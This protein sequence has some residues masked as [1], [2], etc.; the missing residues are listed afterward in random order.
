[1]LRA[2]NGLFIS[3]FVWCMLPLIWSFYILFSTIF[4]LLPITIDGRV[5]ALPKVSNFAICKALHTKGLLT[6]GQYATEVK[7]FNASEKETITGYTYLILPITLFLQ[8]Y[9]T[10]DWLLKLIVLK[11]FQPAHSKQSKKLAIFTYFSYSLGVS[12]NKAKTL[13]VRAGDIGLIQAISVSSPVFAV[14][15]FLNVEPTLLQCIIASIAVIG[16]ILFIESLGNGLHITYEASDTLVYTGVASLIGAYILLMFYL[17]ITP[18]SHEILFLISI[19]AILIGSLGYPIVHELAHRKGKRAKLLYNILSYILLMPTFKIFHNKGHH[20]DLIGT[21]SD[22]VVADYNES[23]IK[24]LLRQVLH[25]SKKGYQ[26]AKF[27]YI[28]LRAIEFLILGALYYIDPLMALAAVTIQIYAFIILETINYVEHYSLAAEPDSKNRSVDSINLLLNHSFFNVGY[29]SH[30]HT[31]PSVHHYDLEPKSK[32][33]TNY[34]YI[35]Q[36]Y[37]AY[38]PGTWKAHQANLKQ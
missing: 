11:V 20:K 4:R 21:T 16:G 29:H 36:F 17:W 7:I 8:N 19:S 26:L 37:M 27:T 25:T 18:Y 33:T 28:K 34:G 3:L 2:I 24:Y 22:D 14:G 9:N 13:F 15:I 10:F 32:Y 6:D 38:M 12:I 35:S 23:I 31:N 30:H 5:E 1:M